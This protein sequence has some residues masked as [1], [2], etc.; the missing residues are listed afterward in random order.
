MTQYPTKTGFYGSFGG[1]FVPETLMYAVKQL[2]TV[3]REAQADAS[4]QAELQEYLQEYVGRETP[5]YHAQRCQNL[6]EAR[7]FESYGCP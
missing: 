5:L 1:K 2:E 6:S 4:F 3:Y 7:R